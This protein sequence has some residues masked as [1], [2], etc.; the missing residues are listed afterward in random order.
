MDNAGIT[1]IN[2]QGNISGKGGWRFRDA[3]KLHSIANSLYRRVFNSIGCPL[4]SG[5]NVINCSLGDFESGYDHML[6]IDV[7]LRCGNQ[8]L[9]LQEK[10][11]FTKFKTVTVEYMQNPS[12]GELGD[13]FNLKA[14]LY[15]VGYDYPKTGR[16]FSDWIL[17]N[18]PDVVIATRK[19]LI[20]WK[21][22]KNTHDNARA[23]FRYVSFN[24]I[25]KQC[26]LAKG[27]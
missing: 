24:E 22:L 19:G 1:R 18:W 11:L 25:P 14:Q 6:G 27:Q 3:A 12:T 9:T 15:F 8:V 10:F 26:I 5:D 17:L 13:W 7:I 21:L 23:S 2:I 4:D 20:K 16:R